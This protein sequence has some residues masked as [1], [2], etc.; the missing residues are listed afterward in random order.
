MTCTIAPARSL[1]ACALLIAILGGGP[2]VAAEPLAPRTQTAV[3]SPAPRDWSVGV[4]AGG[5]VG[6]FFSHHGS[7]TASAGRRLL[8]RLDLDLTLRV[9]A[10]AGMFM[11]EPGLRGAVRLTMSPRWDLLLSFRVGYAALRFVHTF[12]NHT[13][14]WVH[15]LSVG[16]GVEVTYDISDAWQLR[17]SP[18]VLCG[19][20]NQLWGVVLEP[21]AG[22]VYRF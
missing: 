8:D 13:A 12:D 19:Y 4:Q 17:L 16:P 1:S 7:I 21:G 5:A 22:I 6:L 10:G 15:L 14:F 2:T 11:M 18:L 20:W 3:A 9:G